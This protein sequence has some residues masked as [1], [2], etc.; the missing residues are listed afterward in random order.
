MHSKFVAPILLAIL[1]LAVGA[2]NVLVFSDLY[3]SLGAAVVAG[4]EAGQRSMQRQQEMEDRR[5]QQEFDRQERLER[6]ELEREIDH[7]RRQIAEQRKQLQHLSVKMESQRAAAH[8]DQ[9]AG[10]RVRSEP[11]LQSPTTWVR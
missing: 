8:E 9:S 1:P 4:T 3:Q 7:Q 2:Q 11:R 10:T 6:M 5:R